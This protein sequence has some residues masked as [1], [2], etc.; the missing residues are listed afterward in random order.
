MSKESSNNNG[1]TAT[2]VNNPILNMMS[3]KIEPLTAVLSLQ[4]TPQLELGS[5]ED[6]ANVKFALLIGL[7][8][9]IYFVI[10]IEYTRTELI[11]F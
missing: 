3:N 7:I 1:G 6:N 9:V 11:L 5:N 10:N 8:E 2:T 4:L